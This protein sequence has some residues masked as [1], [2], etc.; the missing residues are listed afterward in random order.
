MTELAESGT[1][2][3]LP[4]AVFARYLSESTRARLRDLDVGYLDLTGN[5]RIILSKPGLVIETEGA[6]VD[7]DRQQRPARTLR[8]S[9]AGRIVRLLVDRKSPPR[10]RIRRTVVA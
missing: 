5:I 6:S 2:D 10:H 7:P 8:G 3:G 9:K 4:L 1:T